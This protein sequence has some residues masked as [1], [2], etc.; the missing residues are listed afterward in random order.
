MAE[1]KIITGEDKNFK[2]AT[3]EIERKMASYIN[4][5]WKPLGGIQIEYITYYGFK[6]A[7]VILKE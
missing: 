5:G 4:S 6:I 1:Y 7:Q 3:E 2:D